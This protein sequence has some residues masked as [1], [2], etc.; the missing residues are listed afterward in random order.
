MSYYHVIAKVRPDDNFRCLFSDLSAKELRRQFLRPYQLGKSFFSRN[1]LISPADLKSMHIIR[2]KRADEVERD[3]INR[4][5]KARIDELNRSSEHLVFLN[6]G[7]GYEPE[8]ILAAGED[9]THAFINGPP[10]YNA[11]WNVFPARVIGW[12]LSIVAVV[13]AAGLVKWFGWV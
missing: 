5:Q 11:G 8:D 9:V 4:A 6:F 12:V 1:D 7:G 2:T 13:I 10:G 3:E